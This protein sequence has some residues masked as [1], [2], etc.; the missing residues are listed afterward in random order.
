MAQGSRFIVI[1]GIDGAGTTT[2]T[3][4]LARRLRGEG[5]TVVTT[6]EPSSG[7]VGALI[8]EALG[9]RLREKGS[10]PIELDWATL[11]LLFAADRSDHV[12]RCIA[13]ALSAGADVV[14]D[15]YD[16]S[17]CIYQSL[18][19]PEP[20]QA[21]HW[22]RQL[23][24]QARRPDLTLVIHVDPA[25]AEQR[26]QARGSEPE[27]FEQRSLQ[28]RLAIAYRESQLYVPDDRLVHVDGEASIDDVTDM[29]YTAYRTLD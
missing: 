20:E 6:C 22:I 15:R 9:K 28:Q 10:T 19:S 2:Q 11:A 1:E 26:R 29:L 25:R 4:R 21:L 7:P 16:L 14:C 13:P 8:R 17:S 12:A 24:H 18:T 27:L 5:R 23:N 3:E